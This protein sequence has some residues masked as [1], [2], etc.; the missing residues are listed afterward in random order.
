MRKTS[1]LLAMDRKVCPTCCRRLIFPQTC[2]LQ[3]YMCRL[4]KRMNRLI[5]PTDDLARGRA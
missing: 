2:A 3:A 4:R 1:V 5:A